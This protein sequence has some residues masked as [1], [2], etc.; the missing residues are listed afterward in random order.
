M[1]GLREAGEAASHPI[2]GYG[3]VAT[4]LGRAYV[5]S[6]FRSPVNYAVTGVAMALR[7][8][9]EVLS[10]NLPDSSVIPGGPVS[11]APPGTSRFE[12]WL[13]EQGMPEPVA[14]ELGL[15]IDGR[16]FFHSLDRELAGARRSID[17]QTFIFDNDDF[18]VDFARRLKKRSEA[19]KVRVM[20]DDLGTSLS[21]A[22]APDTPAPDDFEPPVTIAKILKSRPD[23]IE[24][25]RTLN[26]WL[27]ADHTKLYV[28]DDKIA[29]LGG[30]NIGREYRS[31]WHD[32]MVRVTGPATQVLT[33]DFDARWRSCRF[34]GK[35]PGAGRVGDDVDPATNARRGLRILRTDVV[36]GRFEV[37]TAAVSAIRSAKKRVWMETPYFS[38]DSVQ[39]ELVA[40]ARRGVDVRLVL[41]GTSDSRLMRLANGATAV[42]LIR[43]GGRAYI[44]P[45]M[46]HLKALVCDDWA[47]VGSANYDTLSMAINRELN[48]ATAEPGFVGEL[49]RR[50][51][52]R[53]FRE[54]RTIK[55]EE[56]DAVMSRIAEA[57]ADQL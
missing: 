27:V 47:M 23:P 10:G 7:R 42:D 50:V 5:S 56:V 13:T 24:M 36:D 9:A 22:V 53:D 29:F 32:M 34:P 15:L 4:T 16:E 52:R 1:A 20:Y 31:E 37:L 25:R 17:I 54:S 41:P 2:T 33:E 43:A 6:A 28:F 18:A 30:M 26:P 44:Y 46:T 45:G 49:S 40:A 39:R 11:P 19:V 35:L 55:E 8:P 21:S 12:D 3:Q 57:V 51:F 38:S 14:G 48:I